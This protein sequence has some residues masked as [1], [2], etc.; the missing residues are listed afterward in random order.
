MHILTIGNTPINVFG[1]IN[2]TEVQ[3]S[4]AQ[5]SRFIK[6]AG[7]SAIT[8]AALMPDCH[9]G[10]TVPIGTV[11]ESQDVVYPSLIGFDIGCG[12]CAVPTTFDISR[13][14]SNAKN[15]FEAIH[16]HVPTGFTHNS[17]TRKWEE[18]DELNKTDFMKHTFEKDG[19]GFK[20]LGTL[21]GGNHF[22]EIG[23]GNDGRVWVVIHS[24]SRNIGHKTAT[25]YMKKAGG[26]AAR[27]GAFGF[28]VGA[29]IAHEYW[30]DLEFCLAFALENRRQILKGIEAAMSAGGR[31]KFLWD[32]LVNR[33]HNHATLRE[34]HGI[35]H[36]KGAT[37]AE[38]GM[39]GVIPGNMRDGSFVVRGKG[40]IDSLY[41]SSHGAGRVMG[42]REA[43]ENLDLQK[44]KETMDGITCTAS[45]DTLD[46]S[47][48]AYKDIFQVMAEQDDLVE[49]ICHIIPILN[50]KAGGDE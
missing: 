43:K 44:F 22:I 2:A 40:N 19:T 9:Q 32:E 49:I 6:D 48:F 39:T 41:S 37:H 4:I 1:D 46:E 24:G 25:Y 30:T 23:A 33:N 12:M 11:L 31:G 16:K 26:G 36:R 8:K 50:V 38:L 5:L 45:I 10:Y 34:G 7:E 21:G 28:H 27:E 20:Q 29:Q 13:V 14:R 3:K 35:I 47:P 15:I 17:K 18:Y 42:R